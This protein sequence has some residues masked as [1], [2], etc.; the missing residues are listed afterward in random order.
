[1]TA[2]LAQ[3]VG[4]AVEWLLVVYVAVVMGHL[5]LQVLLCE[6]HHRR[7]LRRTAAARGRD[8]TRASWPSVD[9]LVPTYAEDPDSLDAC[10]ASLAAQEYGGRIR[11]YVVDDGSPDPGACR[12][13]FERWAA[14]DGW[15]V[16]LSPQNRG[17]RHAQDLAFGLGDGELVLTVDS[18]TQLAPDAVTACVARFDDVRVGAVTGNVRVA[19]A[20][21]NLLTRLIDLRYWVAFNQE[22][23]SQSLFGAVLCCS[24]PLSMYRREVLA[25]VWPAYVEQWFRGGLCTYG[26]DRHLT[27]LVLSGGHRTAYVEDAHAITN[28]PTHLRGYLRQ[29]LRWNK[30]YYRELLWTLSFLPR[31]GVA[32]AVEVLVQAVLPFLLMFALAVTAFRSLHEGPEVIV[33]YVAVVALMA[34]AHCLYGLARTRDPRFLLFVGYGFLHAALL[35]PV[36][37]RA[38]TSLTDVSWGTRG[39]TARVT[40]GPAEGPATAEATRTLDVRTSPAS[41]DASA[42][43]TPDLAPDLARDLTDP[44]GLAPLPL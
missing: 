1:M 4:T 29:Q 34:V 44:N 3:A 43:R 11:V 35:I 38:L 21:A 28:A 2:L 30:S 39:L 37:M 10:C 23:A 32:M 42:V 18:D 26:D 14:R 8:A 13:V 15:T 25:P 16:V 20:D 22:R 41:A 24:G 9:V 6:L 5:A 17:K 27:N 7:S 40:A 12:E 19:N 31:L 33:R 36:R